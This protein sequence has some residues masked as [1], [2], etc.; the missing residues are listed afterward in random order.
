MDFATKFD[1]PALAD[2]IP[3]QV[4]RAALAPWLGD[5]IQISRLSGGYSNENYRVSQGAHAYVAR[6]CRH[7]GTAASVEAAVLKR[8]RRRVP[9]PNVVAFDPAPPD[10]GRPLMLTDWLPGVSLDTVEDSLGPGAIAAIG[11]DLGAMLARVHAIAFDRAGFFA[12]GLTVARP[13]D[14]LADGWLGFMASCLGAPLA[15]TRLGPDRT[16]ALRMLMEHFHPRLAWLEPAARL[17]HSDL[18]QKNIL[19]AEERGQWRVTGILDWE[20]AFAGP[21]LVD[22]GNF[23][24]FED[25]QPAY[26][27]PLT[28][29][30][31]AAGGTLPDDWRA[32]ARFL[33]LAAMLDFVSDPRDRPR[34]IATACSVIDETLSILSPRTGDGPPDTGGAS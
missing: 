15:Q 25:E 12:P 30:Y 5:D 31:R 10:L 32:M 4:L 20:F 13:L 22:F 26:A 33:D 19:V 1:P 11:Q 28:A 8:L 23:L 16:Q 3:P 29:G 9:V 34:R 7:D 27:A 17:I 14:P 6:V 18:N 2:P 24:R 21:P